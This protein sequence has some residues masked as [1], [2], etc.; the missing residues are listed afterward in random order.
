MLVALVGMS[1]AGKDTLANILAE[2]HGWEII[3][4]YTT[5]QRRPGERDDAYI[6]SDYETYAKHCTEHKVHEVVE[7]AGFTYWTLVEDYDHAGKRK[8]VIVEPTGA[9]KLWMED[10]AFIVYVHTDQVHR[11]ARVGAER[12]NRDDK[13]FDAFPTDYIL[14]NNTQSMIDDV[15][16]NFLAWA[17]RL[18]KCP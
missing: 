7:Y 4:S 2:N 5:R 12:V 6:W 1:G 10:N 3:R 17:K 14:M 15:V 18:N 13:R 9:A 11:I 8:I 16:P